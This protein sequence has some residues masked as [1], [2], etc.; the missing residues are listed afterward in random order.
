MEGVCLGCS[1]LQGVTCI[2]YLVRGLFRTV[3]GILNLKVEKLINWNSSL[4][5]SCDFGSINNNFMSVK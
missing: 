3:V 2:L 5:V 1:L 4:I